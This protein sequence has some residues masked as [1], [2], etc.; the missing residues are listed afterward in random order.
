MAEAAA[1]NS[2]PVAASEDVSRGEA[3]VFGAFNSFPVAA[4]VRTQVLQYLT[5]FNSFP[6]AA[7]APV[8]IVRRIESPLKLSILSQLLQQPRG[9]EGGWDRG[10]FQFF[11]SCC[12]KKNAAKRDVEDFSDVLFLS[13]LSQLLHSVTYLDATE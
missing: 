5:A 7:C 1:F 9:G 4:L 2:F 8:R 10:H 13:I 3:D 12:K 6:V 11:P